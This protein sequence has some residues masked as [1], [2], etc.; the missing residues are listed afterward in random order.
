MPSG[1]VGPEEATESMSSNLKGNGVFGTAEIRSSRPRS[2]KLHV[3]SCVFMFEL[4]K[5]VPELQWNLSDMDTIWAEEGFL[6]K[7]CLDLR[8]YFVFTAFG[9]QRISVLNYF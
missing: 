4:K 8:S 7:M 2:K 5:R 3:G 1:A 6:I 9:E